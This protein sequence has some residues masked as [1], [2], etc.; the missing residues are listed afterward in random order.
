[1][2]PPRH[3]S[4]PSAR[5]ATHNSG[6]QGP[7]RRGNGDEGPSREIKL[8][9][10]DCYVTD[11]QGVVLMT[12]LGSCV[13]A[14]IRDPI[15]GIGGMNHFLLPDGG[16]Y[17]ASNAGSATRY[18][19][20]AMEQLINGILKLGGQKHRLEV[21]VFGGGNVIDTA[22]MI[23]ERNVEFVRDFLR[24]EGL[25]IASEDL[26]DTYPRR[27]NYY[28]STGRVMLRKLRR[29]EDMVVVEEERQFARKISQKPI[30][31]D[32]DLF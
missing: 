2:Q 5:T 15:T 25:Q 8:F 18:G 32:I 21:K 26:G 20:F 29:R 27:V 11:E 1:M 28:P 14:C 12:I 17:G 10:G 24:R 7:E 19:A 30:E 4:S 9:S 3:S 6:Y 22:T 13:A 16:D 23:G 31:G